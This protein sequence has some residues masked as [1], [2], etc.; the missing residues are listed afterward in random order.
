MEKSFRG[1]SHWTRWQVLIAGII[2]QT[3]I[4]GIYAWST[5]VPA[6]VE[7][8]GY[9]TGQTGLII[10]LQIAVFSSITIPGGKLLYAWGP[11]TTAAV[12]AVLFGA[13]YVAAS[14][15]AHSFPLLL[16]FL[17]GVSGTGIGLVYVCPLTTG[18]LWF[19]RN[20]GIVTGAAVSGFGLGAVIL[21]L[22][23]EYLMRQGGLGVD[24]MF[25]VTGG[26]FGGVALCAALL[27]KTPHSM[28]RPREEAGDG[29][30]PTMR[31]TLIFRFIQYAMFAG[32][33]SGLLLSGNLTPF[34]LN[35]GGSEAQ[36]ALSISL[37]A[38]GNTLG[39]L[40]WGGV[41]DRHKSRWTIRCS[42][43]LLTVVLLAM[44]VLGG[45]D[46]IRLQL[47]LIILAGFGFGACFVVYAATVVE[48]FGVASLPKMYPF[49]FMGYGA[50]ALIAPAFGGWSA[51]RTGSYTTGIVISAAVVAVAFFLTVLLRTYFTSAKEEIH[52]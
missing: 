35:M 37:F 34:I 28:G 13:G 4:G 5:F 20:R 7:T 26:L 51:D 45:P 32:T 3:A 31:G 29:S 50:A 24:E 41:H 25:R 18:M 19:P 38:V 23:A 10:G 52:A 11:R 1:S 15:F 14:Y 36:A 44:S 33:F 8:Y 48:I 16:F 43:G 2:L 27:L 17:G 46:M 47:L 39:R 12:G 21:S 42:L 22:T 30:R 49:V 40:I 6:L 9:R